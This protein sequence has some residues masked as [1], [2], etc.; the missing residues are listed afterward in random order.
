MENKK[1]LKDALADMEAAKQ[2][3]ADY[4]IEFAAEIEAESAQ[5]RALDARMAALTQEERRKVL[6]AA[7]L[8][9]ISAAPPP[10]TPIKGAW[11]AAPWTEPRKA[12]AT[13][14]APASEVRTPAAAPVLRQQE[15]EQ[16]TTHKIRNREA[17]ILN[18]EIVQARAKAPDPDATASV[19]GE[20]TKLAESKFGVMIGFSS[21]GIQYRGRKYQATQEPDVFTLDN[22]RDRLARARAKARIDA[23]SRT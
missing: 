15:A 17:A 20:L 21:D 23:P 16:R 14:P 5:R 4:E 12:A 22:L 6:N 10:I 1:T 2:R 7:R 11:G 9:H 19:W 13:T 3:K 18:A 8:K